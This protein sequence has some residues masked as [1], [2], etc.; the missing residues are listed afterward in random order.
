VTDAQRLAQKLVDWVA[1][2]TQLDPE[3]GQLA[4]VEDWRRNAE[5]LFEQVLSDCR[6]P[7]HRVQPSPAVEPA[8]EEE[9]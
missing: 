6:C 9:P 3:K 1:T 8:R 2:V 4:N 5:A 7:C